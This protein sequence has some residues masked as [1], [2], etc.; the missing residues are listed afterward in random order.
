MPAA[1]S[2]RS[3]LRRMAG[4]AEP[5]TVARIGRGCLAFAG[6]YCQSCADS[7]EPRAI[8]FVPLPGRPPTPV[9]AD[10]LCTGCGECAASCPAAAIA[11]PEAS[12]A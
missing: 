10:A 6:V 8:R 5:P 12:H 4:A 1:A 3:F 2:R 11:L 9:V 7:C